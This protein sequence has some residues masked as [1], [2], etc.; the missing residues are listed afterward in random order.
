M[1]LNYKSKLSKRKMEIKILKSEL[2][3]LS[4]KLRQSL[5]NEL[6]LN[7]RLIERDNEIHIL[8]TEDNDHISASN[9]SK[10]LKITDLNQKIS[11]QKQE[12][13][14]LTDAMQDLRASQNDQKQTIEGLEIQNKALSDENLKLKIELSLNDEISSSKHSKDGNQSY[15]GKKILDNSFKFLKSKFP[16]NQAQSIYDSPVKSVSSVNS[17]K[18]GSMCKRR[19]CM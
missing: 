17:V 9:L 8:K 6:E 10:D 13:Q 15:I 18:T 2:D 16:K 3:Q 19:K 5:E 7:D 14:N 4:A 1:E 12:I 11:S